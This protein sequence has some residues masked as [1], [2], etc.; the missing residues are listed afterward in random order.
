MSTGARL[1]GLRPALV[2]REQACKVFTRDAHAGV[3][4]FESQ[5]AAAPPQGHQHPAAPRVAH[6]VVHQ[7]DQ[8]LSQQ[9]RVGVDHRARPTD[10]GTQPQATSVCRLVTGGQ[11]IAQQLARVDGFQ[12][13][14]LAWPAGAA[15]VA[16]FEQAVAQRLHRQGHTAQ[17]RHGGLQAGVARTHGNAFGQQH[18]CVHGLTQV[19]AGHGGAVLDVG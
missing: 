17:L 11:H 6:G 14:G 4:N 16:V 9:Y 15:G 3:M 2:G 12:A 5:R 7:V 8:R 10:P 13:G 1:H 18:Q 19:V